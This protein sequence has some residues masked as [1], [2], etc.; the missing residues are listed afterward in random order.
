M[1]GVTWLEVSV[2]LIPV[3]IFVALVVAFWRIFRE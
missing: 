1:D 2:L 3:A